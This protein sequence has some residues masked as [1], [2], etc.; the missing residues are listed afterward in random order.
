MGDWQERLDE[1]TE[2]NQAQASLINDGEH[3]LVVGEGKHEIEKTT[4]RALF[5]ARTGSGNAQR[6]TVARMHANGIFPTAYE[7][8][9]HKYAS[10][11]ATSEEQLRERLDEYKSPN[12]I[13]FQ[14]PWLKPPADVSAL[15]R[16]VVEAAGTVQ[17]AGDRLF[18]SVTV[19]PKAHSRLGTYV[20]KYNLP[21]LLDYAITQQYTVT[22]D[23][24]F[25]YSLRDEGYI[26]YSGGGN[27]IHWSV[28]G[29]KH[30]GIRD[31]AITLCF[32]KNATDEGLESN[33]LESKTNATSDLVANNHSTTSKV[34]ETTAVTGKDPEEGHE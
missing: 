8:G 4:S 9:E 26:H 28:V 19:N 6:A 7:G 34:S 17:R 30:K 23:T 15:L 13:L 27:N 14:F 12:N 16:Q 25:V 31:Y 5:K 29:E 18:I 10:L 32:T 21:G 24:Q 3:V 33:G 22:K 20:L 1:L 11:D 2:S